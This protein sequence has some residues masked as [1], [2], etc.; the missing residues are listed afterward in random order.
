MADEHGMPPRPKWLNFEDM[1][2]VEDTRGAP[3]QEPAKV[4]E[5]ARRE[6]AFKISGQNWLVLSFVSP[7]GTFQ[8]A[9]N[10]EFKFRGVFDTEREA[11]KWSAYVKQQD[12]HFD[13]WVIAMW[14]WV[15]FPPPASIERA[16]DNPASKMFNDY[17]QGKESDRTDIQERIENIKLE[18][19]RAADGAAEGPAVTMQ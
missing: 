4:V 11:R 7:T 17:F 3:S 16:G 13:V 14:N 10:M 5:A 1:G 15:P 8:R 12:P 18:N 2:P 9:D 6:D 19:A